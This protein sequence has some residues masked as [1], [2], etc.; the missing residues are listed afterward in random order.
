MRILGDEA[1]MTIETGVLN[2]REPAVDLV[3]VISDGT[4][5]S[6]PQALKE[7]VSNAYDADALRVDISIDED[8]NAFAIK[9]DGVGMTLNEFRDYFASIARTGKSAARTPLGKTRL[10]R[11]KIGRFGIGALA[12]AGLAD[13]FVVR[14]SRRGSTEGFEAS[15]DLH[16]LRNRFGRGEDLSKHWRFEYKR[17]DDEKPQSHFTEVRVEGVNGNVRSVLQRPG[18]RAPD[19]FIESTAR[20]SGRDELVWQL[21]II[22]PVAYEQ[23]YP[24]AQAA[25]DNKKDPII[26]RHSRRLLRD[27]FE[28]FLNGRQVRR[29]IRLPS[30][31]PGEPTDTEKQALR[32]AL[33]EKRGAGWEV[34]CFKASRGSALAC[35]GY[36]LVQASQLFP[37]ELR[38]IL[39]RLRGIAVGWH[40]TLSLKPPRGLST[41]LSNMSGEVWVEGLEDALQF[42]RESFR[43]DQP[44]FRWL[45]QRLEEEVNEAALEFRRRS[46]RRRATERGSQKVALHPTSQPAEAKTL[47]VL[48]LRTGTGFLLPEAL[49]GAPSYVMRIVPQ[50]NGCWERG[51]Y[52]ACSVMI[53]RLLETLIIHLYYQRGWIAELKDQKTNDFVGLKRMVDKVSG[54]G[55]IGLESKASSDLKRLKELGDISAHDFRVT[56]KRGDLESM[57]DALRFTSERLIFKAGGTGP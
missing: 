33:L 12:V 11:L 7:F 15:I 53:R 6:F 17:W 26:V 8:C 27:R 44:D 51:W 4:Y 46:A 45:R 22:C 29:R 47:K 18:E 37:Y 10:G 36:L 14:S 50:I 13:R 19:E 35:E 20:L 2:P 1:S 38:G 9:D 49:S 32:R 28:L 16:G 3:R 23:T 39:V 5:T 30:Y 52:E 56:V 21:G 40:R 41:M 24:L 25:I 43:E 42:D 55:R 57:R 54:D 31:R 48:P 34:H